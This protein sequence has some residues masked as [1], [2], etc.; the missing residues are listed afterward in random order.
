MRFRFLVDEPADGPHNMA[1]DETIYRSALA[2]AGLATVRL[3]GF[4]PPTVSYGYRQELSDVID[5]RACRELGIEWVQR[6]T[7]GRALLHQHELTYA[8]A[9]PVE[10]PLSA[11]SVRGVYDFVNRAIRNGLTRIGVPLDRDEPSLRTRGEKPPL[12]LPCLAV[13]ERHEITA[14]GRKLVASAQRRTT[15][16]FLQHGSILFRVDEALWGRI[17]APGGRSR[18]EAVGI[19][20]LISDLPAPSALSSALRWAFEQAFQGEA[21]PGE[22]DEKERSL[23][24]SLRTGYATR[25]PRRRVLVG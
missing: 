12:A 1:V 14:G 18:L 15:R 4:R 19:A 16:G 13:P 22:L 21:E 25:S 24:S 7:G 6:P 9:A 10:G 2:P 11:L 8:V 5:E 20:D 3:Y 17:A 23:V